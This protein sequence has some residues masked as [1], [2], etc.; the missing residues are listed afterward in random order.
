MLLLPHS[1]AVQKYAKHLLVPFAE[2]VPY[3]EE[4][5]FLNAIQWNFGLGGWAF[6]TDTTLFTFRPRGD[7]T[8]APASF[9]NLICYESAYPGYVASFV[10]KGAEFLTVMTNDSWWGNTSGAYQHRQ[11]A[12]MRAVENRRWVVQCANGGISAVVDPYGRV[13]A[14]RG[15]YAEASFQAAV[16][17]LDGL[18]FYTEHGDWLAELCLMLSSFFL[19]AAL[20]ARFYAARRRG[21]S[22]P[23]E[24]P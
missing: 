13:T 3:S 11:F 22:I 21:G 17:P 12:V 14:E 9:A 15:M 1:A 23:E 16:T 4:L 5:S 6:G 8:H 18:T 2:R 7:R 20:G 19:V 24:A 10:R